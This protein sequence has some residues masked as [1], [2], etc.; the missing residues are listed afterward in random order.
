[1]AGVRLRTPA[2]IP[3]SGRWGSKSDPSH[4][5][6]VLGE[7]TAKK[8][9]LTRQAEADRYRLYVRAL[10][11][12]DAYNKYVFAEGP[13]PD[14][15]LGVFSAGPG[16]FSTDLKGFERTMLGKLASETTPPR[17]KPTTRTPP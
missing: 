8:T 16:T 11:S 5:V 15:R 17:P 3:R 7:P 13:P 14:L 10:G 6:E 1:M 9:E 2:A 4:P 12:P